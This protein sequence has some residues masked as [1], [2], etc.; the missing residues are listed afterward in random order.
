MTRELSPMSTSPRA[1]LAGALLATMLTGVILMPCLT[2][3]AQVAVKGDT[4]Y[5][6]AGKPLANGVVLIKGGR[7]GQ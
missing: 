5:T 7:I 1:R 4:V 6:M 2:A 3:S